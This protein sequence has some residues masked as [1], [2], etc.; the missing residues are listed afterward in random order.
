MS[1]T[2]IDDNIQKN[3]AQFIANIKVDR[4]PKSEQLRGDGKY[5]NVKV[6]INVSDEFYLGNSELFTSLGMMNFY[7]AMGE[8]GKSMGLTSMF[9]ALQIMHQICKWNPEWE[10]LVHCQAGRNRSPTVKSAF[11]YMMTGEHEKIDDNRLL[12]NIEK[13]HL[14]DLETTELFLRT[15]KDAFDNPQKFLVVCTTG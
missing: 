6:V 13:N 14:P 11:I 9:S 4:F 12:L 10:I 8:S 5:A 7:F 15:C 2:V 3:I 1:K